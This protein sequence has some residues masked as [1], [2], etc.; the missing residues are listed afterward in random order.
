M[1]IVVADQPPPLVQKTQG[2]V[3]LAGTGGTTQ[4]GRAP[5][6][7]APQ[8]DRRGVDGVQDRRPGA[9][10]AT[11][12]RAPVMAP[13]GSVRLAAVTRPPCASTI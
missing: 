3:A 6:V 4:K 13:E 11:S 9:G 12:N 7:G 1:D 5:A 2:K 10:S 8:G